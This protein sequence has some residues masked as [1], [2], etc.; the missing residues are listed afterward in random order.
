MAEAKRSGGAVGTTWNLSEVNSV[1]PAAASQWALLTVVLAE[2]GDREIR[3][4]L[5]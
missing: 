2:A 1:A 5:K 3:K 4:F